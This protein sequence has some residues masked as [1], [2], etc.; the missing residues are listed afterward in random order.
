[1]EI[2]KYRRADRPETV[3]SEALMAGLKKTMIATA[4]S[5]AST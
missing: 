4:Q 2:P 3:T 5:L 1:M